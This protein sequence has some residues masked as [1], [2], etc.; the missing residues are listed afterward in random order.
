VR[1]LD[2]DPDLGRFLG[3]EERTEIRSLTLP[4]VHLAADEPEVG[5][6]LADCHAFGAVV[7]D[8]ML[9][10]RLR[11][12]TQ[13]AMR[14]IGPGDVVAAAAPRPSTLLAQSG[15]QV[16]AETRLAILGPDFLVGARRWPGLIAGLHVRA[17]EQ[18][19]RV[20]A[21]LV[22]CQLPRVAD[23]LLAMMW[24]LAESWGRVTPAGTTLPLVLTHEAL[25]A[26]IGARRPT[27]SLALGELI[28]RGAIV[29]QQP[30]WLLLER[31]PESAPQE[32]SAELPALLERD[33]SL[34]RDVS[35]ASYDPEQ[36]SIGS[37]L[38]ATVHRLRGELVRIREETNSTVAAVRSYRE[39]ISRRRAQSGG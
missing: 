33:D 8:G 10:Q 32:S 37:E 22:I 12:G 39:R 16:I 24:L 20:S 23:R 14:L 21:Q 28:E 26:L 7:V 4:V 9:L 36:Q 17:A 35:P 34:W 6:S 19:E 11:L 1:L 13:D 18:A 25:G 29:R 5:Q 3:E 31:L 2:V 38:L 27:V 15:R 30:G